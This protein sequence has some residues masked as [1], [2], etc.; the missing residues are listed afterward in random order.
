MKIDE[1]YAEK[2][3]ESSD[4]NEHLPTL[5]EYAS[6]C[7]N[8]TEFGVR[9][10]VSTWALIAGRPEH[11]TS[12]DLSSPGDEALCQIRMVATEAGV[13][14]LFLQK[15][16]RIGP[17][18]QPTDLLF[19]DTFHVYEQLRREL[20]LHAEM[21]KKWIILHDTETFGEKGEAGEELG[22]NY[23]IREFLMANDDWVEF[24]RFKNNNGLTILRRVPR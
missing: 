1:I 22:L 19:I 20:R 6:K 5:K 16:V 2:C 15:D 14:F 17:P 10:V 4:I 18:I 24:S 23:A 7:Q 3:A 12:Y 9:G 11:L 21:V 8:V 13:G